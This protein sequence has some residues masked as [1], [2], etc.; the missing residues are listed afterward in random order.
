MN[1]ALLFTL[2]LS[3][4]ELFPCN[5]LLAKL[6]CVERKRAVTVLFEGNE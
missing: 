5:I 3:R 4:A 1:H 2:R 6:S